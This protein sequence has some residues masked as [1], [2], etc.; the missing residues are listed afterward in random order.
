MKKVSKL[1]CYFF[2]SFHLELLTNCLFF[3]EW[4]GRNIYWQ[5]KRQMV[6]DTLPYSHAT[7]H[8]STTTFF[9]SH[10]SSFAH[11]R[12]KGI[13][14]G[15]WTS[16]TLVLC[17]ITWWRARSNWTKRIFYRG[18]YELGCGWHRK[19][20]RETKGV[21]FVVVGDVGDIN[22]LNVGNPGVGSQGS[23]LANRFLLLM[24]KNSEKNVF[25]SGYKLLLPN[26]SAS[27]PHA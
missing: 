6:F 8:W 13:Y 15:Q 4:M 11:F 2:F 20:E 10:R 24:T 22:G 9:R 18:C 5:K 7:Y 23:L 19:L 12:V 21:A 1:V 16:D 3:G 25:L 26:G 27:I 14:A 17:T